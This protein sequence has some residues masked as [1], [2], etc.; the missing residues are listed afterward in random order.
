MTETEKPFTP[1]ITSPITEWIELLQHSKTSLKALGCM[2][3]IGNALGSENCPARLKI[4]EIDCDVSTNDRAIGGIDGEIKLDSK[5]CAKYAHHLLAVINKFGRSK[6]KSQE[7]CMLDFDVVG[8][9]CSF[10]KK[11]KPG[12]SY[13]ELSKET[14]NTVEAFYQFF[15][16][17][18][19]DAFH[20]IGQ[21]VSM[22][23]IIVNYAIVSI[24]FE[25]NVA[26][27]SPL[28]EATR[29]Q[30]LDAVI[31]LIS[32]GADV[33]CKDE[34]GFPPLH[35]AIELNF[36][37]IAK[38]LIVFGAD[39]KLVKIKGK[40]VQQYCV[41]Q[42]KLLDG[43]GIRGL[44]LTTVI[45]DEIEKTIPDFFE[46]FKFVAGTSTG[47]ILAL[48][49]CQGKSIAKCRNIYFKFKDFVFTKGKG[50]N[51]D[52]KKTYVED[53]NEMTMYQLGYAGSQDTLNDA[54]DCFAT[55]TD[56]EG[57]E[58]DDIEEP[59]IC[60]RIQEMCNEVSVMTGI[61]RAK[62]REQMKMNRDPQIARVHAVARCTSAAPSYFHSAED[63]KYVDGGVLNNN[64]SMV[65]LNEFL[66]WNNAQK[67]KKEALR[68]DDGDELKLGAVVSIG[69]GKE[70]PKANTND[71]C[72][73]RPS[74]RGGCYDIC[75]L[76][77]MVCKLKGEIG[78]SDGEVVQQ[79]DTLTKS[80]AG[81]QQL[82][83]LFTDIFCNKALVVYQLCVREVDDHLKRNSAFQDGAFFRF[84]PIFKEEILLDETDN[85][86]LIEM[87]WDTKI[88]KS[89]AKIV[90]NERSTYNAHDVDLYAHQMCFRACIS[91]ALAPDTGDLGM[92]NH[93]I[94]R[95]DKTE[96]S[97][98]DL[99]A[100]LANG[101]DDE[102]T[103]ENVQMLLNAIISI[104]HGHHIDRASPL[105]EAVKAQ[106]LD[107][108]IMLLSH[109]VNVNSVNRKSFT[110]LY[111]SVKFDYFVITKT[112]IVFCSDLTVKRA[113]EEEAEI[114][115]VELA[116]SDKMRTIIKNVTSPSATPYYVD[117][118]TAENLM[119][120]NVRK[121][122]KKHLMSLDGGGIRGL[123]LTTILNELDSKIPGIFNHI[124][125]VAGTS[126]GSILAL[127]LAHGKT[128]DQCRNIYFKFKDAVFTPSKVDYLVYDTDILECFLKDIFTKPDGTQTTMHE[129]GKMS[130][131]K[132]I[133]TTVDA[134]RDKL[135]TELFK[136]YK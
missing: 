135:K 58:Q 38:T 43:G 61:G 48:A 98:E 63:G 123:V 111:Y 126:T 37:F 65:L 20:A 72:P 96:Q 76:A 112:L 128:I 113:D 56:D 122:K 104:G 132:L 57:K 64:P 136:S 60:V 89:R 17:H 16:E 6:Y 8:T 21:V 10:F 119:K 74:G 35:H 115:S 59:T 86:T 34:N 114:V 1:E 93:D 71:Q 79:S 46:K 49:M 41:N 83:L 77:E 19:N 118:K 29:S 120:V 117:E 70:K 87:M 108:V 47:S 18:N 107:A 100:F 124:K 3:Y 51:Y 84:Q 27:H 127:A 11:T 55:C 105:H 66:A 33:N 88:S 54:P 81:F 67:R 36:P 73:C 90:N 22:V 129:L 14:N 92:R 101:D 97:I 44:V 82:L 26:S 5:N 53:G 9:F 23:I 134:S 25:Y 125:W 15:V 45:M 102:C 39:H 94:R 24:D 95:R 99:S 42:A 121:G 52:E 7:R 91:F 12:W 106:E 13:T 31:M 78:K 75:H 116:K 62:P 80:Q 32:Y 110:A 68:K 130:G 40:S 69:T 2:V 103:K 109:E 50:I 4:S 133:S 85:Q 131:K 30:D 28:F